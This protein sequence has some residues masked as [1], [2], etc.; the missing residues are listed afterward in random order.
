MLQTEY[1]FEL[2]CGLPDERGDLHR[3]GAMR[4]ATARDEVEPLADP[5]VRANPAYLGVLLLSRVITRLGRLGPATPELIERLFSAD[6]AHLQD[7]YVR[8]ND[9]GNVVE[10]QCP[11]CGARFALDLAAADEA[12]GA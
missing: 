5:R 2:P 4:L 12:V 9:P 3:Q 10:T 6:F 8:L 1:E 7:L 11:R